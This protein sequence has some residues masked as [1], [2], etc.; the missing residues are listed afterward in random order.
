MKRNFWKLA[1]VVYRGHYSFDS[2]FY[3]SFKRVV[4]LS[5]RK[6]WDMLLFL[7]ARHD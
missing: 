4:F 7:E 5:L 6:Y 2:T 3:R 1:D